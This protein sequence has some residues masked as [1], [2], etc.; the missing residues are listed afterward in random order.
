MDIGDGKK[1]TLSLNERYER[2]NVALSGP[3]WVEEVFE[4]KR[5]ERCNEVW[6]GDARLECHIEF[7]DQAKEKTC[8]WSQMDF[9]NQI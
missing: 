6:E 3:T 7:G 8:Y 1:G 4:K 2:C 9:P 5:M